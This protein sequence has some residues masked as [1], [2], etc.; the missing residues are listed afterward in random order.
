MTGHVIDQI[1]GISGTG[2]LDEDDS[3]RHDFL[4]AHDRVFPC[5]ACAEGAFQSYVLSWSPNIVSTPGGEVPA[6]VT[7]YTDL[8]WSIL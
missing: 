6:V 2:L 1:S 5:A 7:S 4:M 8:E 3:T